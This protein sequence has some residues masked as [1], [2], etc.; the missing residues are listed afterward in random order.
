MKLRSA[1]AVAATVVV[2]LV[3]TLLTQ[4]APPPTPEDPVAQQ[5]LE[6]MLAAYAQ[7]NAYQSSVHFDMDIQQGRWNTVRSADIEVAF[8]RANQR[9]AVDMPDITVVNDGEHLWMKFAQSPGQHLK[10]TAPERFDL[11]SSVKV[12]PIGDEQL[13]P[14]L[15]LLMDEDW[16]GALQAKG[17]KSVEQHP[18]DPEAGPGIQFE[19]KLGVM[20]LWLDPESHLVTRGQLEI[21]PEQ[22]GQA[23][24]TF[25]LNY[26]VDVTARQEPLDKDQAFGFDTTDSQGHAS[27]G[28]LQQAMFA[29]APAPGGSG[30]EAGGASGAD[31]LVGLEAPAIELETL[32]GES[33]KLEDQTA[34]VVVIDFWATWCGPCRRGLP[35]LEKFHTW[36]KDNDKSVAVYAVNVQEGADMVREYWQKEGFTLPVLMDAEGS[37]AQAYRVQGIPQTVVISGGKVAHVHVGLSPQLDQMLQSQA[38]ALL[39]ETT[40]TD[41]ETEVGDQGDSA[42]DAGE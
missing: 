6:E 11:A 25:T 24:T 12:V 36:A 14:D 41:T 1:F 13:P 10:M 8:D 26:S 3:T 5:R 32:D 35:M 18:S 21:S 2:V 19:N 42:A 31:G 28:E 40:E 22:H 4:A 15:V 34:K 37:V 39:A 20:T 23:D 9:V 33:F 30:G 29:N 27:L 38:E 7:T 17:V 16:D